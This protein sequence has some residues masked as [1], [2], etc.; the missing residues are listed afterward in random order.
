MTGW[1]VIRDIETG[2]PRGIW[3]TWD[4]DKPNITACGAWGW[5]AELLSVKPQGRKCKQC[6]LH[7]KHKDLAKYRREKDSRK[8][9]PKETI[10][11]HFTPD[12]QAPVAPVITMSEINKIVKEERRHITPDLALDI[13]ESGME[14][15]NLLDFSDE[16]RILGR[17]VQPMQNYED[18]S[19]D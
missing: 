18:G 17:H 4:T 10:I 5:P 2:E 9:G 16:R 3:H 6:M 1:A 12:K 7:L 11:R 14:R 19:W 8:R 13:Y 15:N